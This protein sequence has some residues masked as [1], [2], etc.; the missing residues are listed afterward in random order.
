MDEPEPE[1]E[2]MRTFAGYDLI[3]QIGRGGM[4]VVWRAREEGLDREVALKM[5]AA[6]DWAGPDEV[7]RFRMEAETEARFE[8]PNIVPVYAVGEF[9]GRPFF[10]M[11][12]ALGTLAS[13]K[14]LTGNR[15]AAEMLAKIG[16]AVHFAH[17]RGVLHRDLKPANILLD[18]DGTP[19]VCDFGFAHFRV[20]E[21]FT[22]TGTGI[23]TPSYMAPEQASGGSAPITTATD[24]YG[25]GALLY[26]Q[27]TGH[28]PFEGTD[29]L[30]ILRQLASDEPVAPRTLNET[31]DKDLEQIA[32]KAMAKRPGD[33]YRSAAAFVDDL[34]RWLRGEPTVARPA[35]PAVRIWKWARRKP[36]TAVAV[37][38]TLAGAAV[39]A[40]VITNGEFAIRHERNLAFVA[41]ADAQK[42]ARHA[43]ESERRMRLNLYA[44]DMMVTS[45]AL[46]DGHLGVARETLERHIP[47]PGKEDLRGF[48]WFAFQ[49]DC[50]GDDLRVLAGHAK[51]VDAVAFSKD[52]KSLATTGRDGQILFWNVGTGAMFQRL[53]RPDTPTNAMEIP[54]FAKHVAG[55]PEARAML[56][57]N[58]GS[59]D[60]MRMRWRPSKIG[61][62]L[63][64]A[65]SPDGRWLV[66]GGAGSYMRVWEV[67]SGTISWFAPVY[68]ISAIEFTEDGAH[69]VATRIHSDGATATLLIYDFEQRTLVRSIENVRPTFALLNR[70]NDILI[71]KHGNMVER[72]NL[73][74]GTAESEFDTGSSVSAITAAP[75]S[76]IAATIDSSGTIISLWDLDRGARIHRF[77]NP[78]SERFRDIALSPDGRLLAAVGADHLLRL[79]D[80]PTLTERTRLR[81]HGDEILTVRFSPG[82]SLVVTGGNDHTARLWSV[83]AR[84]PVE[85]AGESSASIVASSLTGRHVLFQHKDGT[86]ECWDCSAEHA[87]RTPP[88]YERV[89]A[90]FLSDGTGFI[91]TRSDS[92]G[93]IVVEN[94]STSGEPTRPPKTLVPSLQDWKLT[95]FS[96]SLHRLAVSDGKKMFQLMDLDTG[97][98]DAPV[99]LARR[100]F[101]RMSFSPDGRFIVA[102]SWPDRVS[103]ID[104]AHGS[105]TTRHSISQGPPSSSAIS[106]DSRLLATSGDDNLITIHDMET[107][108]IFATLRGHKAKVQAI[109]FTPDGRTLASSSADRTLRL[110]H[111]PTGRELGVL[112]S[113]VEYTS[114]AFAAN[115]VRL[116]TVGP[117]GRGV[118]EGRSF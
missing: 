31:I 9:E 6:A 78:G 60:A 61:G 54:I 91:T 13:R 55:S 73:I 109:A 89:A 79:V 82:G 39:L 68:A 1:E 66:S 80:I 70:G 92:Q 28:A 29:T 84:P 23:G 74:T 94:W 50:R 36:A 72:Q 115:P 19:M 22:L 71:A 45:R 5:L 14:T 41:E 64:L 32:L 62:T 44:A 3:Q 4:G 58:P 69:F 24:V 106:P 113:D 37:G 12:L 35:G 83:A 8:H 34:E 40:T 100:A 110:W 26:H 67:E 59:F 98:P 30:A 97:V 81:G 33:R 43:R 53:P 17:E 52:G 86:V 107:G 15:D 95:A 57:S 42:Q 114:L 46:R 104:T 47:K 65:W 116:L 16:D 20:T 101:D 102:Y 56:A 63:A 105:K 10:T 87:P 75:S 108:T 117:G 99:D 77:A 49:A 88:V 103:I 51:A 118:I 38:L 111:I 76:P 48:E 21:S 112:K 85:A 2:V 27:L 11:K 93:G 18:S 96:A 7:R 90:G 25:L